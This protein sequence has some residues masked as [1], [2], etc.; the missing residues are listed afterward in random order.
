M[1]QTASSEYLR[2]AVLTARP[3]QLQLMLYD[4]AIRFATTAREALTRNDLESSCEALLRA[5][6]IV[7]ELESGLRHDVNPNLCS[8]MA[9]LYQFVYRRLVDANTQRD[10]DA[11]DDALQILRHQRETWELLLRKLAETADAPTALER[12]E[13]PSLCVQG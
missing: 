5:Q 13:H 7:V 1:S 11:I 8:Q 9:A 12:S 3:E 2:N 6:R 10:V 4:G